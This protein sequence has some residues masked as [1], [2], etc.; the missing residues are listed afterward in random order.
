MT[1]ILASLRS[2]GVADRDLRTSGLALEPTYEYPPDAPRVLTGHTLRN[3]VVARL[4]DLDRVPEA[5]DG[6]LAAGAT[7]L[8]GLTFDV[9]DRAVPEAVARAAAVADALAKAAVLA[10]A[11]G[12]AIGPVLSIA[13][14]FTEPDPLPRPMMMARQASADS[15][16]VEGGEQAIVVNVELVLGLLG[17]ASSSEPA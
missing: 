15:T 12:V 4:R 16:P 7:S 10:R 3:A 6:A 2:S 9:A 1:A 8:D 13:E 17:P 5:I 14:G 11:A